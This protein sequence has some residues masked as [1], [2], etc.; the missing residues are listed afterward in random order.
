MV[1]IDPEYYVIGY[2][3][4]GLFCSQAEQMLQ[5]SPGIVKFDNQPC[6]TAK[7]IIRIMDSIAVVGDRQLPPLPP[8]NYQQVNKAT[9][10]IRFEGKSGD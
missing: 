7:M 5:T 1:T 10:E 3:P 9:L 2:V 4:G 8:S 6:V